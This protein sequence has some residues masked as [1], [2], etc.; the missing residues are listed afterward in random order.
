MSKPVDKRLY[1]N[2]LQKAE[3]M[4]ESAMHSLGTSK[5][6]AAVASCIQCDKFA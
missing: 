3:E 6:N 2:Y 1:K 4:L 5:N